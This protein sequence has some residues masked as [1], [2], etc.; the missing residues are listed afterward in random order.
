MERRVIHAQFHVA[1]EAMGSIQSWRAD[2]KSDARELEGGI[3]IKSKGSG[4]T[5]VIPFSNIRS[6]EVQEKKEQAS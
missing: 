4:R 1:I 6:Y 5:I 2:R 3:E